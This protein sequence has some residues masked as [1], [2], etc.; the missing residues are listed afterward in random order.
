ME[1][2]TLRKEGFKTRAFYDNNNYICIYILPGSL[3][4]SSADCRPTME[5]S[6]D[7]L[8]CQDVRRGR[9]GVRRICDRV[10]PISTCIPTSG[11]K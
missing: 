8:C 5:S 10:T 4:D 3:C 9:Q 1:G 2:T 7:A 11:R 6:G